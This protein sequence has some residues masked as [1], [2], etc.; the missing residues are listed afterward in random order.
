MQPRRRPRRGKLP[1]AP[2]PRATW[3]P[4]QELPGTAR[5]RPRS[6]EPGPATVK[7]PPPSLPGALLPGGGHS[8]EEAGELL[9]AARP[10]MEVLVPEGDVGEPLVGEHELGVGAL[11]SR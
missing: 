7:A 9:G 10:S 6:S 5:G 2:S 4:S 3:R 1:T 8:S 11:T